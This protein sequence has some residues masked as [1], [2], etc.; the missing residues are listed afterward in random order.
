M[1]VSSLSFIFIYFCDAGDQ[2]QRHGHARYTLYHWA[3]TP[4][5]IISFSRWYV[6]MLRK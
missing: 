4:T 6:S 1:T 3:I 2:T 5:N